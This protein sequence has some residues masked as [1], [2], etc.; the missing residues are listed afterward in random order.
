MRD[1]S[2]AKLE[3]SEIISQDELKK[4]QLLRMTAPQPDELCSGDSFQ[5]YIDDEKQ[6]FYEMILLD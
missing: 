5:N 3:P 2:R 1:Q 4:G 6:F